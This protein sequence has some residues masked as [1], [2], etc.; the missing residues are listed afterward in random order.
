MATLESVKTKMQGLIDTANGATANS[1]AD[2]TS[3][4]NSLVAG[5]GGGG[6]AS[7]Q[8]I[9]ETDFVMDS[10]IT[11]NGV[12]CTIETGLSDTMVTV[13]NELVFA[14]ITCTPSSTPTTKWV[15]KLIQFISPN[16]GSIQAPAFGFYIE[17]AANQTTVLRKPFTSGVGAYMTTV[18]TDLSSITINARFN[19]TPP[20]VGDYHMELYRMGVVV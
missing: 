18:T 7:Y 9:Y 19:I 17:I 1:D 13:G 11:A 16:Q 15:K 12:I 8:K 14:V 20:A 2:L 3:A 10:S 5:F 4:I 6:G